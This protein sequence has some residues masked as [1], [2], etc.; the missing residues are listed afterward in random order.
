MI[1]ANR[2]KAV[3]GCSAL[4]E[5]CDYIEIDCF[6]ACRNRLAVKSVFGHQFFIQLERD[7]YL[8][9]GLQLVCEDGSDIHVFR[10]EEPAF[11]LE[12]LCGEF[13]KASRQEM[14]FELGHQLGNLHLPTEFFE[15]SVVGPLVTGRDSIN[16]LSEK[17]SGD[18][19]VTFFSAQLGLYRPLFGIRGGHR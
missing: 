5:N 16:R 2:V 13:E 9:H 15:G 11:R 7:T 14:H 6:Q 17:F 12:I 4:K 18:L 8:S 10:P 19:K 3:T 1:I